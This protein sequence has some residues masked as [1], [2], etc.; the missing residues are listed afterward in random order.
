[1]D[2]STRVLKRLA[3]TRWGASGR[4]LRRTHV[5]YG[6]A[7]AFYGLGTYVPYLSAAQLA[8]LDAAQGRA[9]RVITGCTRTSS[10]V[11]AQ[12]L[13]DIELAEYVGWRA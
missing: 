6:L 1:M 4:L 13:A 11:A 9:A 12:Q 10:T 2:E 7:K 8:R 5:Q 3:G